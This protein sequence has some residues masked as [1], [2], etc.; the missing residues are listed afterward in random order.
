MAERML[1]HA[2]DSVGTSD[3]SVLGVGG[4]RTFPDDAVD[5]AAQRE[6]VLRGLDSEPA[7]ATR[8]MPRLLAESDLVITFERDHRVEMYQYAPAMLSRCFLL[9]ELAAIS[10]AA[11]E[12][13]QL[14]RTERVFGASRLRH[15]GAHATD[16]PETWRRPSSTCTDAASLIEE[17]TARV[18]LF[19]A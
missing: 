11:P 14:P 15:L 8:L 10:E 4:H 19:L 13:R 12:L 3:V 17:A 2:L 16:L 9:T 6:L 18:A 5:P 1:R 7:G